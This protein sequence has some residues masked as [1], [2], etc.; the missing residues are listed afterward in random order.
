M[1]WVRALSL[2]ELSS[3]MLFLALLCDL[4]LFCVFCFRMERKSQT[5]R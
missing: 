4:I 2:A 5:G 3:H 1:N